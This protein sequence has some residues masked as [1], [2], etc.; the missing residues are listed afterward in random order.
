MAATQ[1]KEYDITVF[2]FLE[3]TTNALVAHKLNMSQYCDAAS[4]KANDIWG[5]IN[6]RTEFRT[7]EII[8][9]F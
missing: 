1:E 3:S 8:V 2:I 7:Q 6:K 5:V 4:K 9:L